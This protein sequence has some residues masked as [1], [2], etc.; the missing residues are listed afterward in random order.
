MLAHLASLQS[1]HFIQVF[2]SLERPKA[3][4]ASDQ[5]AH[6]RAGFFVAP[7]TPHPTDRFHKFASE[8]GSTENNHLTSENF[9]QG[10]HDEEEGKLG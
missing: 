3:I 8:P 10:E 7:P 9:N 4:I 2:T 6:K 1:F 5:L